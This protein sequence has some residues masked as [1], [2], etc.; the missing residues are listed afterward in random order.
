MDSWFF[1]CFPLNVMFYIVYVN[2]PLVHGLTR[3]E[4]DQVE[5][6]EDAPNELNASVILP[7]ATR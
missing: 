6:V 5:R 7:I 1:L 2:K 3:R 4:A